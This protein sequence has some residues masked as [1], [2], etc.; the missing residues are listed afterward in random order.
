MSRTIRA[1]GVYPAP[2]EE[3]H[4][5]MGLLET[6]IPGFIGMTERGPT[7]E[8]VRV[9]SLEDFHYTFGRLDEASYL[10]DAIKGFFA[11][12][13][14]QAYVLRVAHLVRRGRE[15]VARAAELRI[16]GAQG[17]DT[18]ALY[19]ADEGAW[20]NQVKV[21]VV[22][23]EPRASTFLTLDLSEGDT[24]AVVKSTHGLE[25]GTLIRIRDKEKEC[26]RVISSL[27]GKTIVWEDQDELKESFESGAPTYIE[28]VEFT[29]TVDAPGGREVFK[30]LSLAP[31]SANYVERVINARSHLISVQDLSTDVD[32]AASMPVAVETAY[33]TGGADGLSTVTPEDYVGVNI[34]P[35]ERF[36][37]AAL[38]AVEEIDLLVAP[39]LMWALKNSH[40][41]RTETDVEVV[42]QAMISQ[43]ERLKTRFAI[44]DFPDPID[45]RKASQWRLLF[46]SAYGAFYFPW[47][48]V[49][50]E[51]GERRLIPPSGHV[52][53]VYAKCDEKMGAYRAPANEPL[54]GIVGLGRD[55]F[56]HDIAQLNQEGI[57][58][59]K[60][61]PR[62]GIRV[63]GARTVS[64]DPQWI[65][66]NV[67]RVV[68]TVIRSVARG[69]QWS[70]FETNNPKLWKSLEL[71]VG[72]FLRTLWTKGFFSGATPEESFYVKCDGETNTQET[73]DAGMV[74]IECGVAPVRPAEYLV[75][76]V[77][78]EL[79]QAVPET[80]G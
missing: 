23:Q 59:L 77:E 76:R 47:L 27:S 25:R 73:R 53:G 26:Y 54:E 20:G 49:D 61:F 60:A 31:S 8:P 57:N 16:Q 14:R 4:Q 67:R 55:L 7:N 65:F 34:G 3:R 13:G 41:F 17:Q 24:A 45:H 43:C 10:A 56:E 40:G 62:R 12:G 33:L 46:D 22:P 69:L 78:S 64:S 36:G 29:I 48:Q 37:L 75:F 1:P 79:P 68:S 18:L 42:Q 72:S 32:L 70:V 6:G 2:V 63:W 66:I 38:E 80:P 39:D 50:N 21:S 28:P 74:I 58:C 15:E 30:N 19:A 5:R 35:D 9:T 71:Q 11:N 44:M 51:A 52:A